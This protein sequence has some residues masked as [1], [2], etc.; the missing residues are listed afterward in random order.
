[1]T[2]PLA[3]SVATPAER[4]LLAPV[5]HTVI[6]I[7]ILFAIAAYGVY[8]QHVAAQTPPPAS[9]GS[10]LPL[11]LALLVAEWA[12]VRYVMVGLRKGG[13]PFREILGRR[14]T[15][16]KDV[17]RDVAIALAVFAIWT[18]GSGVV[19]HFTRAQTAKA[20]ENMLPRGVA[21]IAVWILLSLSAGFCEEVV[22]RGY[23]QRQ[24]HAL[25]G[26]GIAAVALQAVIFGISHGYQGVRNMLFITVYG[27]LFGALALWRRS[28]KPGM[29]L[30][31]WTD[32]FGGIIQK[33][34]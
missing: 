23:L 17:L 16:W 6:L 33:S 28:L 26:S 20:V 8:G 29:I 18:A 22:Y 21:E 7:A 9:R 13:T 24:F 25:T 27:A 30:H 1:M 14:W 2:E 15:G 19:D 3:P 12:L 34:F 32:I 4:R 10:T 11:Y 31:A 5:R